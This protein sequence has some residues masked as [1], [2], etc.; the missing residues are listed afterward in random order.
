[1]SSASVLRVTVILAVRASL[2]L[3]KIQTEEVLHPPAIEQINMF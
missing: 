2:P 3:V 1:M